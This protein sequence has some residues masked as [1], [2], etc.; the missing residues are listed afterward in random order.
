MQRPAHDSVHGVFSSAAVA[1][2]NTTAGDY[3]LL[4]GRGRRRQLSPLPMVASAAGAEDLPM[5]SP[6]GGGARSAALHVI[7]AYQTGT[8]ERGS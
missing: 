7:P 8:R 4:G 3:L 6:E 2:N 5:S 1:E